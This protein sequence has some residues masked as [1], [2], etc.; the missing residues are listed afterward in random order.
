[1][2]SRATETQFVV[3]CQPQATAL[4]CHWN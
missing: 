3:L 1:V 4:T 2:I